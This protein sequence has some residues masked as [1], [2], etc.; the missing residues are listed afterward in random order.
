M[1]GIRLVRLSRDESE[2][3]RKEL[4]AVYAGAPDYCT[5]AIGHVPTLE[6][7]RPAELPPGRKPEH[8]YFFGITC[9]TR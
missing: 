4:L 6:E 2:A 5:R 8:D 3:E 7:M 1:H 9:A